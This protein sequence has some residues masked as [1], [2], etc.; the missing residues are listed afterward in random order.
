MQYQYKPTFEQKVYNLINWILSRG[1]Y[2][3]LDKI[4]RIE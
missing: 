2:Q 3:L 1:T 4:H